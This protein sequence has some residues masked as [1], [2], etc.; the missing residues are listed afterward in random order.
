ML[1]VTKLLCGSQNFGD[2]LRYNENAHPRRSGAAAGYG[3]V[4]AW[5]MTR[6]CN[7]RCRHCYAAAGGRPAD[8]ELTTREAKELIADLAAF[9]VPALLLSGGEPLLRPDFFALA[10]YAGSLGLRL[11]LS[12]NGTLITRELARKIK[13][14]GVSYVGISLDG[15]GENND[16]FRGRPGAFA[17]ALEGIRHCVAAGQ[18]VGL[19]FTLNRHNL[20]EL[21]PIFDLVDQEGIERVCFYHLAYAGRGSAMGDQ[22]ITNRER[23]RVMDLIIE[24][25]LDF[26][27]QGKNVEVLTVNNHA[28]AVYLY[29]YLAKNDRERAAEVYRMLRHNGGNRSG[30][31]IAAIDWEGNV[32]PDQFTFQHT[33]GKIKERKFSEIWQDI[34]H[35]LLAGLRNRRGLLKGRCGSCRFLEICNGNS[36]GRAE[37]VY[38]DYWA[39]DPACYLNDDE[40]LAGMED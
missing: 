32:H 40:V 29:L 18:K 13:E 9:R 22:D 16:T 15:T 30:I 24:K 6:A 14:T 37:A 23:R 25:T 20:A 19:R 36:R 5:N 11:T 21:G 7:L 4:V 33:F 8:N 17:A 2:L 35:P 38:G 1:S 31:A 26:C 27:R 12:T 34:S 39:P 28:D 3:P 10:E